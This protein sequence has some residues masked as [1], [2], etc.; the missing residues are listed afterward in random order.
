MGIFDKVFKKEEE[1]K[2]TLGVCIPD[3]SKEKM[4]QKE[5]QV[6]GRGFLVSGIFHVHDSIMVQGKA[7]YGSVKINDRLSLANTSLLVKDIQVERKDVELL[8]EEQ[9]GAL[10]LTTDD[11]KAPIIK[12]GDLLEF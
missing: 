3:K 5:E 2:H 12:A 9:T 11:G 7:V 4:A 1:K 6:D 10:F 8:E